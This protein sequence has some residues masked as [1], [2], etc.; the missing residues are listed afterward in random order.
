MP[1]VP[2]ILSAGSAFRLQLY[3]KLAADL[4]R[5]TGAESLFG[6]MRTNSTLQCPV[7][8][9]FKLLTLIF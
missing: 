4:W 3:C 6:G 5:N 9:L 1:V 8:L 7:T 2:F